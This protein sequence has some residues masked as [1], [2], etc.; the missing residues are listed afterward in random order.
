MRMDAS[1]V[2]GSRLPSRSE[3]FKEDFAA[4]EWSHYPL[5]TPGVYQ[6]YSRATYIYWDP[7]FKRWICLILWDILGSN[8]ELIATLAQFLNLGDKRRASR[9]SKYWSA[10]IAAAGRGPE[11]RDRLSPR[12]FLKRRAL[13]RVETTTRDPVY[14]QVREVAEW[15]TGGIL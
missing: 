10:W 12:V 14:S 4:V 11:R 1:D 6:A 8:D 7:A 9:R 13:V 5:L 15:Q 2:R 3:H